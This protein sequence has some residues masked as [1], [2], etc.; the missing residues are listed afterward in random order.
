[1]YRILGVV[2][3]LLALAA[4]G[5]FVYAVFDSMFGDYVG[6]EVTTVWIITGVAGLATALLWWA[7]VYELRKS[8]IADTTIP[9]SESKDS[10]TRT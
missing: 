8:R 1:M 2:Y 3:A 7:A 5:Y 10:L 9:A 6:G 4:T